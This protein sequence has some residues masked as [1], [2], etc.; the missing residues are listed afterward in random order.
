MA[1][2]ARE[3]DWDSCQLFFVVGFK[4]TF[5]NVIVLWFWQT[6]FPRCCCCFAFKKEIC[7]FFFFF[8]LP[9]RN[10]STKMSILARSTRI[11]I[12]PSVQGD[13]SSAVVP[14]GGTSLYVCSC[15]PLIS[16]RGEEVLWGVASVPAMGDTRHFQTKLS[17]QNNA[18]HSVSAP[19]IRVKFPG[20]W[21]SV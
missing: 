20:F 9:K 15:C 7:L 1:L 14:C 8:N 18:K 19:R 17:A 16:L 12:S 3:A 2:D 11:N 10:N 13:L 21:T 5:K 4:L 6:L